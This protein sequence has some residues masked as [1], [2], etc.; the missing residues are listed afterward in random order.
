MIIVIGLMA[1]GIVI[2]YIFRERNLKFVHKGI[3][4]AI[5]LLLFLLGISVGANDDIMN[6]LET[7]G[8]DALL[9]TMGAVT[10]SVLCAWAVY[11]FF[12]TTTSK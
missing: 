4:Y 12:F 10:G 6:N 7:I 5:F 1:C 3:N 2:G 11:K 8:Y 9:I